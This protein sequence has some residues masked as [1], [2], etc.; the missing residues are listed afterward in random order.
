[1]VYFSSAMRWSSAL[2]LSTAWPPRMLSTAAAIACLSVGD[3]E[4]L[5]EGVRNVQI[6]GGALHAR[7]LVEQFAE[8]R[9]QQVDI[10]TGMRKQRAY[11]TA[12]L[13]EQ[14]NH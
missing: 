7:L 2:A 13:I 4:Q 11:R 9:A 1:M 12:L 8:L 3:V 14:G 5:A 10:D 6:T